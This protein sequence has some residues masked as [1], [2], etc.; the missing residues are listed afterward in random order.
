M[1]LRKRL[2]AIKV[3]VLG[4]NKKD[5]KYNIFGKELTLYPGTIDKDPNKPDTD[6]AWAYALTQNHDKIFD[7][8]ANVGGVSIMASIKNPKKTIVMVDPN[9]LAL[10]TA[11]SNHI[12]NGMSTNK[13]FIAGFVGEKKGEKVKFYTFGTAAAGSMFKT[14]A[15]SAHQANSFLWVDTTTLDNIIEEIQI[16]PELIKIDVESAESY[17]LKGATKTAAL[18]SITFFVEMHGPEEMPMKK[19]AGLILDWCKEHNY[20]AYYMKEHKKIESPDIIAHRGRCHLLLLPAGST[21]P[22]YLEGIKERGAIIE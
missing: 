9:P 19:N 2:A 8:G 18:Q 7:I 17:V 21:Y 5:I 22:K 4:N 1:S 6:A 10:A 12:K 14:H 3:K 16:T 15:I 20:D 13:M 11:A